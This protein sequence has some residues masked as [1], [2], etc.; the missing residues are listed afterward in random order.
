MM[1][2][3]AWAGV[4]TLVV[5]EVRDDSAKKV[6]ALGAAAKEAVASMAARVILTSGF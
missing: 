4:V 3:V 6:V 2:A 5:A 1:V